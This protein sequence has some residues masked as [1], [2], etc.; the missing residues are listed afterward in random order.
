MN[1][2]EAEEPEESE[3]HSGVDAFGRQ[4]GG[5]FR[6]GGGLRRGGGRSYQRIVGISYDPAVENPRG[7]PG[8]R[9]IPNGV[10]SNSA[11]FNSSTRYGGTQQQQGGNGCHGCGKVEHYVRNCPTVQ[12]IGNKN[13]RTGG[14]F[15][16]GQF[17]SFKGQPPRGGR[18]IKIRRNYGGGNF[19][20][21]KPQGISV[22]EE[23]EEL[24]WQ[25]DERSMKRKQMIFTKL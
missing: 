25:E 17:Q 24:V 2:E 1:V 21:A 19:G 23:D 11:Q 4:T 9:G 7:N 15:F 13:F 8:S 16:G 22:V 3:C 20:G 6:R 18:W 10:A 12:S 14:G 5:N